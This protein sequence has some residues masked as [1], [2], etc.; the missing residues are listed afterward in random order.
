MSRPYRMSPETAAVKSARMKALHADPEFRA[1]VS[2]AASA[3]MKALHADPEFRAK[4]SKAL[5]ERSP[6]AEL[7]SHQRKVYRK[8]LRCGVSREE[9]LAEAR[10]S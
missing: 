6:L 7:S 4:V 1:K 2:K 5:R 8:L 10:S 9:A 3:R